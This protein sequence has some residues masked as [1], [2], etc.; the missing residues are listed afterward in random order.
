MDRL[1]C[2]RTR[3]IAT[4]GGITLIVAWLVGCSASSPRTL[5]AVD[6]S[7]SAEPPPVAFDLSMD[8]ASDDETSGLDGGGIGRVDSPRGEAGAAC[9]PTF[10]GCVSFSDATAED[11]DR[12]IHFQNYSYDPKCLIIRSGQTVTFVGDFITHPLTPSCGPELLLEYRDTGATAS[13]V[14]ESSGIYGYYCLDHGNPQGDAMSG[15]IEV[16]P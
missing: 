2:P 15:A 5:V 8:N 12:T 4:V 3:A 10:A 16:V 11:A 14:L 1:E 6:A 9:Q 13:F 7:G